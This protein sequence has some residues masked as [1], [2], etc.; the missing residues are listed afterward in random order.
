[1]S[2]GMPEMVGSS[3]S[4]MVMSKEV[5]VLLPQSSVA[6]YV[7]VVV[8]TSKKS[9]ELWV[10]VKVSRVQLSVAV[11]AVQVTSAP[12]SPAS[13]VWLMS[14]GVSRDHRVFGVG[15]G[16]ELG[17]GRFVATIVHRN[18]HAGDARTSR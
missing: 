15:D 11:G 18:P 14:D 10:E 7:T 12:Q 3:S 13:A 9:P 1:M 4:V 17:V 6:V 2:L 16:D 5:D 8:P